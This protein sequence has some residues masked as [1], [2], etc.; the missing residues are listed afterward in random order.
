MMESIRKANE[1]LTSEITAYVSR[2]LEQPEAL[3]FSAD[4]LA[5][6]HHELSLETQL[7]LKVSILKRKELVVLI[8]ASPLLDALPEARHR[9]GRLLQLHPR[10]GKLSLERKKEQVLIPLRRWRQGDYPYIAEQWAGL[11]KSC[12]CVREKNAITRYRS[13]IRFRVSLLPRTYHEYAERAALLRQRDVLLLA[14]LNILRER[15]NPSHVSPTKARKRR[16]S[17][18][19]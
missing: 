4:T 12:E 5:Q 10:A 13:P 7:N 2:N 18:S 19:T 17:A 3:V 15:T 16:L 14:V 8:P 1:R 9:P 11:L 6:D